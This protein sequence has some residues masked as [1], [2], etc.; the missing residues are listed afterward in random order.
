MSDKTLETL[1]VMSGKIIYAEASEACT[2]ST[3]TI[4]VYEREILACIINCT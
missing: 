3:E 2:N 4:L 1:V